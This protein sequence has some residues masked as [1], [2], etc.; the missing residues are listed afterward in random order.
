MDSYAVD[1]FWS[2]YKNLPEHLQKLADKKYE[3]WR[4]EPFHSSLSFKCVDSRENIWSVRINHEYRALAVRE[5]NDII[6]FWIGD[7][8]TYMKLL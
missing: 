4:Q 6:W 5:G 8:D 7:H 1:S 2:A 3:M